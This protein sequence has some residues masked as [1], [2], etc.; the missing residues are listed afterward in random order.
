MISEV[1]AYLRLP[2]VVGATG[3]DVSGNDVCLHHKD[4]R[5][6]PSNR[7]IPEEL[8]PTSF[9]FKVSFSHT[10]TPSPIKLTGVFCNIFHLL[11]RDSALTQSNKLILHPSLIRSTLTYAAPVW[12]STCSSNYLR[13]QVIQSKYLRVIGNLP[14]RT[15]T[16]HKH[17]S[18]NIK[19]ITFLI[20]RFTDKF[21]PH[22]P[23][24]G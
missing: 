24:E 6:G 23:S 2:C 11:A 18:L 7:N 21:F 17:N 3:G 16:S 19:P 1:L 9:R 10:S 13:L 20:H 12:G 14:R 5:L 15:P 4:Q 22:C 8:N